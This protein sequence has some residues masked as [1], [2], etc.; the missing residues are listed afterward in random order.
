MNLI[1]EGFPKLVKWRLQTEGEPSRVLGW[2]QRKPRG[3]ASAFQLRPNDQGGPLS[4]EGLAGGLRP[5][6]HFHSTPG[7]GRV[8]VGNGQAAA[9]L[10]AVCAPG[11]AAE[12]DG[13]TAAIIVPAELALGLTGFA[14]FFL[15]DFFFR[16][17]AFFLDDF[18]TATFFFDDFFF[19]FFLP[20][21]LAF[22]FAMTSSLRV[23]EQ[24]S[25]AISGRTI[26]PHPGLA[27]RVR[28]EF[29]ALRHQR[30]PLAT[31]S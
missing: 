18:L 15:A 7:Y 9:G 12:D 8:P 23:V 29:H 30:L 2:D 28:A 20:P 22:F 16:P 10:S 11:I 27:P 25:P 1:P 26:Q 19:F 31:R 17:A 3:P 24:R 4:F 5:P 13:G 6:P 21:F 14:F